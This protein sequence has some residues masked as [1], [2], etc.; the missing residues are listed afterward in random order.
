MKLWDY[1][2]ANDLITRFTPLPQRRNHS[3]RSLALQKLPDLVFGVCILNASYW[4]VL[5]FLSK[6]ATSSQIQE[7]VLNTF[8]C[9]ISLDQ[10]LVAGYI[11]WGLKSPLMDLPWVSTCWVSYCASNVLLLLFWCLNQFSEDNSMCLESLL[12]PYQSSG[13]FWS[14]SG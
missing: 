10:Y 1:T 12:A 14:L 3:C 11:L 8:A 13:S 9:Y 5:T 2:R 4:T 7:R 6:V